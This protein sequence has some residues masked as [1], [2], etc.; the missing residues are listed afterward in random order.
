MDTP[1]TQNQRRSGQTPPIETLSGAD[2]SLPELEHEEIPELPSEAVRQLPPPH[3]EKVKAARTDIRAKLK[4][5]SE[6]PP[7]PK[8]SAKSKSTPP[9]K[10][11][12]KI[13]KAYTIDPETGEKKYIEPI[14]PEEGQD[15]AA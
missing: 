12:S 1:N 2:L 3:P 9:P 7:I 14:K 11:K 15:L 4:K 13:P 8:G 6:P 10:P 5:V